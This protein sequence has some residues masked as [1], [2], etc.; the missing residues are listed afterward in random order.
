MAHVYS[1]MFQFDVVCCSVLQCV[2]VG[3]LMSGAW[4]DFFWLVTHS[5]AASLFLFDTSFLCACAA[6]MNMVR[7]DW[8]LC[9]RAV[10]EM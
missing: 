3:L 6:T 4:L 1:N 9:R 8:S 10:C 5:C 7:L 2:V